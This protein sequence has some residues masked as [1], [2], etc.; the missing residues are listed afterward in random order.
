MYFSTI[1]CRNLFPIWL[2][3]LISL[4]F[5]K[6]ESLL[7]FYAITIDMGKILFLYLDIV[8]DLLYALFKLALFLLADID[9]YC[10][11]LYVPSPSS[12]FC[13][14]TFCSICYYHYMC[15][16]LFFSKKLIHVFFHKVELICWFHFAFTG[17]L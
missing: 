3:Y 1:D 12:F 8:M 10:Q 15:T 5:Y 17:L 14:Q 7:H 2:L 13:L 4:R 16:H 6:D 11:F 9:P